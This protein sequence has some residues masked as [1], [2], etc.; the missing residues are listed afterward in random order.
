MRTPEAPVPAA[1]G[2]RQ[3]ALHQVRLLVDP[4]N[5]SRQNWTLRVISIKP[6]AYVS[7]PTAGHS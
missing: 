4:S 7:A 3:A 6:T 2:L 1:R 5:I